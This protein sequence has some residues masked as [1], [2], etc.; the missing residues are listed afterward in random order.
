MNIS[1]MLP[2]FAP[3]VS[4]PQQT[5]EWYQ[6]R[7][8]KLTASNMAT[9]MSYLKNGKESAERAKLK[10]QVVAERLTDIIVPH[11][12]TE[13]MAWGIATEAEAKE[14]AAKLIGLEIKPCGFFDHPE[15]DNFGATPDGLIDDDGLIEIKCPTTTTH[16]AWLLENKIPEQ[17]KPQMAAQLL[18]T[19]RR[20][21]K[22]MSYDPR[23][24]KRPIL[25]KHYAPTE[26]ER[27]AVKRAAML[28]LD[29][30]DELFER[31]STRN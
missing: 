31:V 2:A 11:Y 15:I 28:F 5:P 30:V 8:G 26:A 1:Q 13:A 19:G 22:F 27:D 3:A 25:Y 29:E 16:L 23:V 24:A 12:V 6:S 18:C 21:C 10:M 4:S 7:I 20:Y 17:H 9:A 14:A